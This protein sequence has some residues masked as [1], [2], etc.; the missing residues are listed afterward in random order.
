MS[1]KTLGPA[2]TSKRALAKETPS[3]PLHWLLW[4]ASFGR[5]DMYPHQYDQS[6]LSNECSFHPSGRSWKWKAISTFNVCGLRKLG[7]SGRLGGNWAPRFEQI[8]PLSVGNMKIE[9]QPCVRAPVHSP[10]IRGFAIEHRMTHDDPKYP[11][12]LSLLYA[13]TGRVYIKQ[14]ALARC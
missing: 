7:V 9:Q 13:D 10:N 12:G 14:K 1:N 2:W 4:N 8:T 3:R 5:T 6:L 11:F